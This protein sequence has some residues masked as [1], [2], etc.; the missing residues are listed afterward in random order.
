MGNSFLLMIGALLMLGL[1]TL[2]ANGLIAENERIADEN[3]YYLTS[4]SIAQSIIEEAKSKSFDQATVSAPLD[5]LITLTL[6]GSLGPETGEFVPVPDSLTPNGYLSLT[7]FNDVD[8]YNGYV[9]VVNTPRA[10]GYSVTVHID[11]ASPTWPDSTLTTS[12]FC[13]RMTVT[14][15]SPLVSQAISLQY[16]FIY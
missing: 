11:Y 12:S 8:D 16:A 7:L 1:F 15:T 3:E 6:P 2:T 4:L 10:E 9:R 5:S 13:K 14:V